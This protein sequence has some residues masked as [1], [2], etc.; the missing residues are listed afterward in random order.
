MP[1][2]TEA[3]I[4]AQINWEDIKHIPQNPSTKNGARSIK[5]VFPEYIPESTNAILKRITSQK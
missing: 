2:L 4:M 1:Q 3:E 5:D